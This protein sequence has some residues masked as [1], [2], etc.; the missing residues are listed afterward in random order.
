MLLWQDREKNTQKF[1]EH[2]IPE[3]YVS[4]PSLSGIKESQNPLRQGLFAQS[5]QH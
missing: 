3:M 4:N 2:R 5:K 1:C